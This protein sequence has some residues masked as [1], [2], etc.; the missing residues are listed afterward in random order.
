MQHFKEVL[1]YSFTAEIEKEF[2]GSSSSDI[3]VNEKRIIMIPVD[4]IVNL[5]VKYTILTESC[6]LVISY[7]SWMQYLMCIGIS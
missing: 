4:P 3:M 1:D 7:Y 6:L 2:D 5:K